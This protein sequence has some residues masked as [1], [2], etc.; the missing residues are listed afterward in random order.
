MQKKKASV[1]SLGLEPEKDTNTK[2]RRVSKVLLP[3]TP[4]VSCVY[5]LATSLEGGRIIWLYKGR[6]T[7][8]DKVM[9]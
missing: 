2:K 4:Y 9:P 5:I 6:R 3:V 8:V 7:G 1:V